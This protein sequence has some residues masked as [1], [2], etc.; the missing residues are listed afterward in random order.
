MVIRKTYPQLDKELAKIFSNKNLVKNKGK[1]F[2]TL[3]CKKV[4][5]KKIE[6]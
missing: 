4:H 6:D 3:G 5:D 1:Y 2:T